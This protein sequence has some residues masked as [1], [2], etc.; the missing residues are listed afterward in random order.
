MVTN[1][2]V[3]DENG[4]EQT[5]FEPG[6]TAQIRVPVYNPALDLR[7]CTMTVLID[8]DFE[9]GGSVY[10][11]AYT[12]NLNAGETD[13][14]TFWWN[15]PEE[16]ESGY[17]HVKA[18]MSCPADEPREFIFYNRVAVYKPST[19]FSIM[20]AAYEFGS[21]SMGDVKEKVFTLTNTGDTEIQPE[22][23]QITGASDF[24][25]S[26]NEC[27]GNSMV[28]A[29][30]CTF[31]VAFSPES[32]GFKNAV[33]SIPLSDPSVSASELSL[34]G[35]GSPALPDNDNDGIP[36][37][38]DSDDDNDGMPDDWENQY[39]LNPMSDDADQD[40]D[41]DGSTNLDEYL[42]NTNPGVA[43][44]VYVSFIEP[45]VVVS[46]QGNNRVFFEVENL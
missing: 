24:T 34:S 6:Q 9:D 8:D 1:V 2:T 25:V 36:D 10:E 12:I 39:G 7:T 30:T 11:Q 18:V 32:E 13:L 44:S 4:L 28:P 43:G 14:A 5:H 42:N 26:E 27:S 20:P 16:L 31:R 21:V 29:A 23:L 15:L 35:T 37:E 3:L 40:P 22:A 45:D 19:H 17:Y 33:I 41:N 38:I 46:L